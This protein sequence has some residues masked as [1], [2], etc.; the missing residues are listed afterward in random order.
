MAK[1]ALWLLCTYLVFKLIQYFF[2]AR[3]G[4][5]TAEPSFGQKLL[6]GEPMVFLA[7]CA[8]SIPAALG[9]TWYLQRGYERG[10]ARAADCYGRVGALSHLADAEKQFYGLRTYQAVEAARHAASLAAQQIEMA[11]AEVDK[12]LADRSSFYT[13]RYSSLSRQGDHQAITAHAA[14]VER[15]MNEPLIDF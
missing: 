8:I 11:P 15:C 9:T 14:A 6:R 4:F 12:L 3:P 10:L 1:V 5:E 13:E 2:V 7:A